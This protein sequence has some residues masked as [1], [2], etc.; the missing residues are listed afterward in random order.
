MLCSQSRQTVALC[1]ATLLLATSAQAF[2]FPLS[3]ESIREAYF[4]GQRR[5]ET[6]ARYLHTYSK[7]LAPPKTGPY[8]SSV[9]FLTPFAQLVQ[10]ST[11]H[12]VG[13]SAQQA[14]QDHRNKKEIVEISVNIDFTETYGAIL[15]DPPPARAS[16]PSTYH[17]RS[18]GFWSDFDVQ[19]FDRDNVI[20][21]ATY[22]GRPAYRC[23]YEGGC[24]LTGAMITLTF[25]ASTFDSDSTTVLVTPPEGEPVAVDFDLT[26]LR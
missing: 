23:A 22:T 16:D 26:R 20:E 11:E 10:L 17:L 13:Y 8:I 2:S 12:S 19:V 15:T 7:H 14:Q 9:R 3:I 1:T 18:A 21:P 25:P 6:T 4:L 24:S 5:D